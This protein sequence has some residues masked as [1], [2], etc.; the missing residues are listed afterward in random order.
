MSLYKKE[1]GFTDKDYKEFVDKCSDMIVI[2][3]A[4]DHY[5]WGLWGVVQAK[6]S[7]IDFDFIQ[8]AND[9]L[10]S[11]YQYSLTLL[12][13]YLKFIHNNNK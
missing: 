3:T 10:V 12:P 1:N 6:H 2:F 13:Q 9:R 8:Y 7:P 11:G 4:I 5:F